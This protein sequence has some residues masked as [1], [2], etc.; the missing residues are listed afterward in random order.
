MDLR[1]MFAFTLS[2]GRADEQ[3]SRG[4]QSSH[5]TFSCRSFDSETRNEGLRKRAKGS[6][7]VEPSSRVQSKERKYDNHR[8]WPTHQFRPGPA[9]PT[10]T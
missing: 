9:L 1:S 6:L 5:A 10:T 3:E 2:D 8:S 7:K 4:C